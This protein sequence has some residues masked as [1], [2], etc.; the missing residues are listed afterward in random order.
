MTHPDLDP[1]LT[2]ILYALKDAFTAEDDRAAS[3][4]YA[5]TAFT[6]ETE[7][8][9]YFAYVAWPDDRP[10]G[11]VLDGWF[12]MVRIAKAVQDKLKEPLL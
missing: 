12:D 8:T 9:A 7:A 1:E 5:G 2:R 10:E 4:A 11:V 3:I 6:A